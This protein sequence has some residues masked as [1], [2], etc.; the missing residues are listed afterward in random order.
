MRGVAEALPFMDEAFDHALIVTTIC[1]V[2][3]P[4][5]MVREAARVLKPGGALVIGLIDR[6]STLGREYEARRDREATIVSN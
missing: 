5:A 6:T 4:R 2:D 1:F 3:D